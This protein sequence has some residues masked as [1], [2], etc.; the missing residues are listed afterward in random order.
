M[1]PDNLPYRTFPRDWID[2]Q[3]TWYQYITGQFDGEI[4]WDRKEVRKPPRDS[5]EYSQFPFDEDFTHL[6]ERF[7]LRVKGSRIDP[8]MYEVGTLPTESEYTA[9]PLFHVDTQC[10]FDIWS[11]YN[12]WH[13]D[14]EVELGIGGFARIK[15]PLEKENSP[16][17]KRNQRRTSTGRHY[18]V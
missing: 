13:N 14:T 17:S 9:Q 11:L 5:W 1:I 8:H 7:L 15:I 4:W 18:P 3:P 10:R 16:K 2:E 6:H 12:Q